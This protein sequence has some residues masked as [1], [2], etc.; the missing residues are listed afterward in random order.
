M[1][2]AGLLAAAATTPIGIVFASIKADISCPSG[3]VPPSVSADCYYLYMM[4]SNGISNGSASKAL[5]FL[6]R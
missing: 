3:L 4:A 2:L 1:L 5:P 6:P